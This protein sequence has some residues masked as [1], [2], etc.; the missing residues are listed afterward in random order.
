MMDGGRG[1]GSAHSLLEVLRHLARDNETV[2]LQLAGHASTK[3]GKLVGAE[4]SYVT[5]V[6]EGSHH[7]VVRAE[8][9]EGSSSHVKVYHIP[10]G[11]I[12]TV[13]ER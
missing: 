7:Q 5:L 6:T 8:G 1:R 11:K 10:V 9:M 4:T 13:S 3:V 2:Q 12:V